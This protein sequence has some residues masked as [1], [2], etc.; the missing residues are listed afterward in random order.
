MSSHLGRE[1]GFKDLS[2]E[3][4]IFYLELVSGLV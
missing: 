1:E 2:V 4:S 3:A